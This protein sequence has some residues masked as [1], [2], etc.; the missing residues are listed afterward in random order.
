MFRPT[1]IRS[2]M[3]RILAIVRPAGCWGHQEK[4]LVTAEPAPIPSPA[5]SAGRHSGGSSRC[6]AA[7]RRVMFQPI[8]RGPGMGPA[9][10]PT[11]RGEQRGSS[12]SLKHSPPRRSAGRHRPPRGRL[13]HGERFGDGVGPRA[14]QQ[15]DGGCQRSNSRGT[16]IQRRS[17]ERQREWDMQI[18]E[19]HRRGDPA[20]ECGAGQVDGSRHA[21]GD[22]NVLPL[23]HR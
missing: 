4:P 5:R 16:T 22:G 15:R 7:L 3:S 19:R 13:H 11:R 6:G 10:S 8:S 2:F 12:D 21:G 1:A 17:H 9:T 20:P 18:P 23:G 14:K